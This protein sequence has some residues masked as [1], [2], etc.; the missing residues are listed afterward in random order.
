MA[1]S[2]RE[3]IFKQLETTLKAIQGVGDVTRGK[4]DATTLQRNRSLALYPG[5]DEVAD[6]LGD[7][8]DRTMEVF[9]FAWCMAQ[10]DVT[11]EIEAFLPVVQ[12]ALA[13]DHTVNGLAIDLNEDSVSE[14]IL[15]EQQTEGGFIVNL[16][17][18]YRVRRDDP[19]S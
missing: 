10:T 2:R 11:A 17:C 19:Y 1:D 13:A 12:K 7:S 15:T 4:I 5:A 16:S 18:R 3:R 8:I 9:V 14:R 6:Y